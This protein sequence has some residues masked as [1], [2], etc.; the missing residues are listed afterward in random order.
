MKTKDQLIIEKQDELVD[1]L[2]TECQSSETADLSHSFAES[3]MI[4]LAEISYIE[5][6]LAALKQKAKE[7]QCH[8]IYEKVKEAWTPDIN[9]PL[10][11]EKIIELLKKKIQNLI[12]SDLI[13][14]LY[15]EDFANELIKDLQLTDINTPFLGNS[16]AVIPKTGYLTHSDK[17]K[18]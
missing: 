15:W 6:E 18:V 11:R 7:T 2:E 9:T 1:W 14:P 3:L 10:V 16:G 8:A 17:W 5:F 4:R 13:S 12:V